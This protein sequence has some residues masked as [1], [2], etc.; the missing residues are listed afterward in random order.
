LVHIWAKKSSSGGNNFNDFPANKFSK[1]HFL[2]PENFF[3]WRVGSI[4]AGALCHGT[5]G[6]MVNPALVSCLLYYCKTLPM[7][8]IIDQRIILFWKRAVISEN[9]IIATLAWINRNDVRMILSIYNIPSLNLSQYAIESR[10]W[11]HFVD[12]ACDSGKISVL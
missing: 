12:A 4:T 2:A 8:Y 5:F 11:E 6:T 9:I 3:S 7:S 1:F 10:M